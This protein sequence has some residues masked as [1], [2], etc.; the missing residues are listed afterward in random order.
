MTFSIV[1]VKASIY[2]WRFKPNAPI[3]NASAHIV[4]TSHEKNRF[5]YLNDDIN[6]GSI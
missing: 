6:P 4:L 1:Q 5:S 3:K 2:Q